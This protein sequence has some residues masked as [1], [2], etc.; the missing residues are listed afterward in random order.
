VATLALPD[1]PSALARILEAM[2]AEFDDYLQDSGLY[3]QLVVQLPGHTY[4][5]TMTT[6]LVLD[7]RRRL[8]RTGAGLSG[9]DAQAAR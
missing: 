3:R 4:H 6:G 1:D 8:A 5:P 2:A 9:A 7:A